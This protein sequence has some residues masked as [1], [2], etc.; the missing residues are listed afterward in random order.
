MRGNKENK[1]LH[2]KADKRLR[3]RFAQITF[4]TSFIRKTLYEIPNSSFGKGKYLK[5]ENNRR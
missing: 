5:I 2:L 4:R 3:C 1:Q